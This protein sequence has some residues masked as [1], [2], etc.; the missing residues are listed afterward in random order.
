[1]LFIQESTSPRDNDDFL[2]VSGDGRAADPTGLILEYETPPANVFPA[3]R[4]EVQRD[5]S[6]NDRDSEAAVIALLDNSDSGLN[7]ISPD[8]F[9]ANENEVGINF[10][11]DGDDRAADDPFRFS[12]QRKHMSRSTADEARLNEEMLQQQMRQWVS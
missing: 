6:D 8:I 10:P 7:D 11:D 2:L 9:S 5:D 3:D 4:S 12:L 1:M